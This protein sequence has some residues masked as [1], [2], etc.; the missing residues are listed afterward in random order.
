MFHNLLMEQNENVF[1]NNT[2][3]KILNTKFTIFIRFVILHTHSLIPKMVLSNL[4]LK[5]HNQNSF[6][7]IYGILI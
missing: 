1:Q 4:I 7:K 6:K 5:G 2:E 3:S